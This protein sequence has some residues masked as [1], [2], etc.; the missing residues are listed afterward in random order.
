M[1]TNNEPTNELATNSLQAQ[2][3]DC[4]GTTYVKPVMW[5]TRLASVIALL[6]IL[7]GVF[8]YSQGLFS[9]GIALITVC[10]ACLAILGIIVRASAARFMGYRNTACEDTPLGRYLSSDKTTIRLS[11]PTLSDKEAA[12]ID[13]HRA[14]E[15]VLVNEWVVNARTP[16]R[17]Q[18]RSD[19]GT[20]LAGRMI[21]GTKRLRPWVLMLH[22][23]GGSWRDSLAFSRIYAAHDCNIML[24]DMRA[25][26][27]SEGKWTGSGWLDRRDVIAWC[28]WIIARTGEETQIIIHG[29]GMGATAALFAAEEKDFPIQV[30]AIVSDSAYTDTWNA[31]A[32]RFGKG[33]AKPQPML[34]LY[35]IILKKSKG[36]YDLGI[37]N[38]LP[39]MQ[40]ISTPLFIMHGEKDACT[41][42]YMGMY[43]AKA[44]GCDVDTIL[45][46]VTAKQVMAD[47]AILKAEAL[48]LANRETHISSNNESQPDNTPKTETPSTNVNEIGPSTANQ[49]GALVSIEESSQD[50]EAEPNSDDKIAR[51]HDDATRT[52]TQDTFQEVI[53]D[54]HEDDLSDL[55]VDQQP[56]EDVSP[57]GSEAYP[58]IAAS[59]T[60]NMFF[61][62][63]NAGHCQ[64]S[65]ACP[66]SYENA[67]NTFLNRCIG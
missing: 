60:G 1:S 49:P 11:T 34:D 53:E 30:R 23:F 5:R 40:S 7:L 21:P 46:T 45:D 63:P 37:G 17:I 44:A 18:V 26:G 56:T 13:L 55:V 61:F 6:I 3:I 38:I 41:P 15:A 43:L 20:A 31:T 10:L 19:D 47:I 50:I 64:A 27:E 67:L 54:F 32:L 33:F 59:S 65:F 8:L 48:N 12:T 35:R 62:A 29:I 42:P 14:T 52:R 4:V 28:S 16:R 51:N 25:H 9:I 66:T 24:V 39:S 22:D 58:Y 57:I 36:G 2:S